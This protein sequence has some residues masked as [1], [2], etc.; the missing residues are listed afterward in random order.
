MI[1]VAASM[2]IVWR[3]A[4]RQAIPPRGGTGENAECPLTVIRPRK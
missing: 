4:V 2:R 1:K 3:F